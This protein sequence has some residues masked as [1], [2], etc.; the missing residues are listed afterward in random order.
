MWVHHLFPVLADDSRRFRPRGAKVIV[1]RVRYNP[2]KTSRY[3][4]GRACCAVVDFKH[5]QFTFTMHLSWLYSINAKVLDQRW[6]STSKENLRKY[7][8]AWAAASFLGSVSSDSKQETS[9][10]S[11]P[12]SVKR[13]H[14]G[15][16]KDAA[17]AAESLSANVTC[18]KFIDELC[19]S[20][21]SWK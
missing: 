3:W 4:N 18:S 14:Q 6:V 15:L 13:T 12:Q 8:Y 2:V 17:I 19:C 9:R 11:T 7:T 10:P 5:F 20:H 21:Q 16:P 1:V